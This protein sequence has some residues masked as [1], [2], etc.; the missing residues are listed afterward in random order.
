MNDLVAFIVGIERYA[1]PDWDLP[2]PCANAIAIA[3]WLL[4]IA[5]APG[6]IHL[7]LAPDPDRE[8]AIAGLEAAGVRV[9]RQADFNTID[10][11][12]RTEL[13]RGRAADARLLVYWSGHGFSE[14]DGTRV[15]ICGDY[16]DGGLNNRVYDGSGLCHTLHHSADYQ[17]FREQ[18]FLADV[19]AV[20]SDL[21]FEV[22]RSVPRTPGTAAR[23]VAYFAT[24]E[25]EYARGDNGLGVFTRILLEVL[26]QFGDWPHLDGFVGSMDQAFARAGQVPFRCDC[27]SDRARISNRLVGTIAAGADSPLFHSVWSLLYACSPDLAV[28]RPY[29]RR[30]VAWLG[31][32]GL[33][34]VRELSD[35]IRE[36]ASLGDIAVTGPVPAGLIDFLVRLSAE[37]A[38]AGP[39]ADWLKEHAATQEH[40]Q[41]NARKRIA[42][43]QR[44]KVLIV[45]LHNDPQEDIDY[46]QWSLRTG[47]LVPVSEV[48]AA[49]PLRCEAVAG[50]N[51][52][53]QR[54]P[55]VVLALHAAQ[56]ISEIH[57]AVRPALFDRPFHRIVIGD[58]RLLGE[59]F[60]VLVR[61]LDR[62]RDQ[63]QTQ[64]CW[65]AHAAALRRARPGAVKVLPISRPGTAPAEEEGFC[66]T[67]FT[68]PRAPGSA[69][70]RTLR[71]W[72]R[73]GFPYLVWFHEPPS[74]D[75]W[76]AP[77]QRYADWLKPH[78]TLDKFPEYFTERRMHGQ[79]AAQQVTLLWDDPACNPFDLPRGIEER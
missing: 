71:D 11:F 22:L 69:Q 73:A 52:F 75:D 30:T 59:A 67:R 16:Q 2:G 58:D 13:P 15:F 40:D 12:V 55:S 64:K 19:C 32:P 56:P 74:G 60:V 29:Y 48:P 36:L 42:D 50:W 3:Q 51:D 65:C 54:F 47:H 62:L 34:A 61:D 4:G 23:Q 26:G 7:F 63:S 33:A 79:P 49:L 66:Y 53:V 9:R 10:T 70:K 39:I 24:P 20:H 57:F 27:F 37:P 1:Q 35:M 5:T 45:E 6:N 41:A 8:D 31:N 76:D 25:G 44:K 14:H 18:L 21:K 28:Y 43:E 78:A 38:L 72:L 68:V 17:C 46:C 77:A